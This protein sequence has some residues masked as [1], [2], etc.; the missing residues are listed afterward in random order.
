MIADDRPRRAGATEALLH[1]VDDRAGW[2]LVSARWRAPAGC[3]PA[4]T[5]RSATSSS[6]SGLIG[7]GSRR[8]RRTRRGRR[9]S[10]VRRV[11]GHGHGEHGDDPCRRV[12][13]PAGRRRSLRRRAG[14]GEHDGLRGWVVVEV[15]RSGA[16][17]GRDRRGEALPVERSVG[18]VV[19][20]DLVGRAGMTSALRLG[21][22]DRRLRRGGDGG[23]DRVGAEVDA[24]LGFEAGDDRPGRSRGPCG[25][26]LHELRRR[27][28][29]SWRRT[30]SST[31]RRRRRAGRTRRR[32]PT[33][34]R[35]RCGRGCMPRLAASASC[36]RTWPSSWISVLSACAGPRSSRTMTVRSMKFVTPLG[37]SGPSSGPRS[38]VKPA[39]SIW[40]AI[41]SHSSGGG[42]CAGE[43]LGLRREVGWRDEW[44]WWKTGTSLKP[45]TAGLAS[46]AGVLVDLVRLR[47]DRRVHTER[48]LAL[49][50]AAACP[51]SAGICFHVWNDAT[52]SFGALGGEEQLVVRR[53]AVE[54]AGDAQHR[55]QSSLVVILATASVR[56][57][58]A[59]ARRSSWVPW[60]P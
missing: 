14:F 5:S 19:G 32:R 31:R 23:G 9:A 17:R 7:L 3:P 41:A 1:E 10:S 54:R 24:E 21:R 50:D 51:S 45:T 26:W 4:E 34:L 12:R 16:V 36:I 29:P 49:A 6:A 52:E 59:A 40:S 53:V 57:A 33:R 46:L 13:A 39:A 58:W 30:G 37:P 48:G 38:R 11:V 20:D 18:E 55:C 60:C 28:R 44:P 22:F 25:R 43:E 8:A 2:P 15:S 27:R 35:P 42:S 47:A 56:V